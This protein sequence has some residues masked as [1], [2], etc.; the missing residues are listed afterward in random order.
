MSG[1][2]AALSPDK[3]LHQYVLRI[4]TSDDGM[5][6]SVV[7]SVCQTDDGYLWA[8][9][10]EGLVR[11][12][13]HAFRTYSSATDKEFGSGWIW[14]LKKDA[15][16]R[17]WIATYNA[18]VLRYENEQFTAFRAKEGLTEETARDFAFD[19][20]GSTWVGTNGKGLF[21][22]D[23]SDR[24]TRIS[25]ED[26]LCGDKVM[27]LEMDGK[28]SLW[29]ATLD[30]G[31]CV[32][33]NGQF[34]SLP[35]EGENGL[36]RV[37]SL[38]SGSD[39][40]M[41]VGSLFGLFKVKGG[42]AE[43][44]AHAELPQD[45]VRAIHEDAHKNLWIGMVKKGLCVLRATG[46]LECDEKGG[47]VGYDGILD[48]YEMGADQLFV[49]TGA[50]L[51]F[52]KD[53]SVKTHTMK[54][55]LPTSVV[56]ALLVDSK[57]S[58]WIGTTQGV[59]KMV[60]GDVVEFPQQQQLSSLSIVALYEDD[61]GRRWFGTEQQGIHYLDLDGV[62]RELDKS[63]FTEHF[64]AYSMLQWGDKMVFG[65]IGMGL[66]V[67]DGTQ[68]KSYRESDGLPSDL[69]WAMTPYDEQAIAVGTGRGVVLFD[70]EKLRPLSGAEAT[71][72]D[73]ILS[74][75][76][77]RD[78][79]L[80]MGT[81]GKGLLVFKDQKLRR[82]RTNDGLL[83]D[84]IFGLAQGDE[85]HLWMSASEGIIK[86]PL[87]ELLGFFGG[88]GQKISARRYSLD[89]GMLSKDC[90][91]GQQYGL[92]KSRSGEIFVATQ[93]GTSVID[94][95]HLKPDDD[96]P[97]M[98]IEKFLADGEDVRMGHRIVLKNTVKN[99]EIHFT[100][101]TF[102]DPKNVRFRYRLLGY[103]FA[104]NH[105]GQ[106]RV[107]YYTNLGP[108]RYQFEVSGAN[109]FG[110]WATKASIL[111][112]EKQPHFTQTLTFYFLCVISTLLAIALFVRLRVRTLSRRAQFLDQKVKERTRELESAHRKIVA[113]EK[114]AL[115]RQMAGGFAH[116][117][118]NALASAKML[119][120]KLMKP[121]SLAEEGSGSTSQKMTRALVELVTQLKEVLSKEELSS[122]APL[123]KQINNGQR[124][125]DEYLGKT[126][127][128]I[129][130]CLNVTDEILDYSQAGIRGKGDETI[131]IDG[132][133]HE[134]K[135][136]FVGD[137]AKLGIAFEL[138][139]Q[140]QATWNGSST[141][142]RSILWNLLTNAK[143]ALG[144]KAE[145]GFEPKITLASTQEDSIVTIAVSDNGPGI[146]PKVLEKIFEPFVS[147]KPV[148]GVGLGLSF[149][150]KFAHLY[151]GELQGENRRDGQGA[152]FTLIL[153]LSH[154]PSLSADVD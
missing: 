138:L 80:F 56:R 145:D 109:E 103:Y 137:F 19:K 114:E 46:E 54:D 9:T 12:D 3:K 113:L 30:G 68:I 51:R 94:P 101:I 78:G 99:L 5:P 130:R 14:R 50:S 90:N 119:V 52:L 122:I 18:G 28:N 124:N 23:A 55:G 42:R 77:A 131:D 153:P 24:I 2:S 123:L 26:G 139:G 118:R 152:I 61:K 79:T 67:Y 72:D 13:G 140:S 63:L 127:T 126:Y 10:Q 92:Q 105:V 40:T 128:S 33:Q 117:I 43:K 69:V 75:L 102:R 144:E 150:R 143:D 132:F 106:R 107:A 111:R 96:M 17:L 146:S 88:P 125:I 34:R 32:R 82:I 36:S 38:A 39:G 108:G 45:G 129:D 31:L 149:C 120:G 21:R 64:D 87:Q 115:E 85:G 47:E 65:T 86:A 147:T 97:V 73:I 44:F 41:W 133:L 6:N 142:L 70:G 27:S 71:K 74:F 8:G 84:S 58:I 1:E 135:D 148:T 100:G 48:F 59:R 60:G 57:G 104:W 121:E 37:L 134:I 20:D 62:L 11:F 151:G 112:F 66:K 16:G 141:H 22:F 53:G 136:A 116:E 35:T 15:K 76:K 93:V 95:K 7:Q 25:K 91:G 98:H 81:Q 83:T 154:R 29:V 4:W 110:P 49:G 89:D